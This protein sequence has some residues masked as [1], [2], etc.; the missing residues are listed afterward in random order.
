MSQLPRMKE[1]NA[2]AFK[3]LIEKGNVAVVDTRS[4]LTF[5]SQH[6]PGSWNLDFR[7]NLPI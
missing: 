7:S 6:I 3:E 4:Y 1:L 2:E 5:G